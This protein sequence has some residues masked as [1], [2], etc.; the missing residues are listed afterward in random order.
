VTMG[1]S[2]SAKEH[3]ANREVL[4]SNL[5]A[6][7][8]KAQYGGEVTVV[9]P[10]IG[11]TTLNTN[12]VLMPRWLKVA[13]A[14]DLVTVWFG[15]NDWD[16]GAR[17][18]SFVKVLRFAVDRIRRM[19]GGKSEVLLMTTLPAMPRWDTMEELAAGVREVAAGKRTALADVAAAFHKT[20]AD[21][22]KRPALY[23]SDGVHL[24][25]AGH[26]LAAQT[27]AEAIAGEQ[28]A[29]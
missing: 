18:D 5:L 23:A 28:G 21:E 26:E 16:A 1:D 3:W 25:A 12:L 11:G 19:T 9:N 24:G 29:R 8:L 17:H 14:P 10:A 4:W 15:F 20:G 27:V 22:A 2:L 13:P 6:R 7:K